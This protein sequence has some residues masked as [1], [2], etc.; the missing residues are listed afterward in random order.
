VN[1]SELGT[2]AIVLDLDRVE[3]NIARMAEKASAASVD[4]RPHFKTSKLLE[5]VDMQMAA[6]AVG[7]TC[8][9]DR[10][11]EALLDC[12]VESVLWAHQAIGRQ[13]LDLAVRANRR[14]DVILAVDSVEVAAALDERA[15]REG[16]V[17]PYVIELDTGMHRCGV[18][19]DAAVGLAQELRALSA[20]ELVGVMTH[21]GHVHH[22]VGDPAALVATA[23]AAASDLL[24]AARQCEAAGFALSVTSIGSTPAL[25][26]APIEPGISEVRPG[27]YTFF[28]ANQV[29]IGSAGWDDCAVSVL[30][31]VVSH[32][33]RGSP[34]VDAGLKELSG[35]ASNNGGGYG[36]VVEAGATLAHAYEEHGV[37]EAGSAGRLA[38]GDMVR[39]VP[40]HVCG[41]VNMWS[42]VTVV[43]GETVIGEWATRGRR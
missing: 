30:A 33:R 21:E 40:N 24:E 32:N 6:G 3:R 4:L 15:S 13:R 38:V 41:A 14:A 34:V 2:P 16:I 7:M 31:R 25:T 17:V 39:I 12:G 36:R 23:R 10:E 26:T 19:P 35:D 18:R 5:V 29:A 1:V 11:L 27:T 8:A 9:T 42:R 20:I 43:R 22:H 28:D 37:L